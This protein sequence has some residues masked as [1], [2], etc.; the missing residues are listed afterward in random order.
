MYDRYSRQLLFSGIGEEGQSKI[1]SSRAV[2]VGCGALGSVQADLLARAGVG[3]LNIIDRDFLELSNL[4]RQTLFDEQDL[5]AGLPK[6]VA[7]ERRLKRI[8]SQIEIEGLVEDLNYSNGEELLQGADVI[9]DGTDN[10]ET[11]FLINDISVK[12]NIP[13]IYGACVGS[14]GLTMAVLPGEGPCLRCLLEQPPAGGETCDTAGV[15]APVVYAVA[16]LQAAEALKILAGRRA[17][18]NRKLVSIDVWEGRFVSIETAKARNENC[19]TCGKRQFEYLAGKAGSH[20]IRLCGRNAVQINSRSDKRL[21]FADLAERLR[22]HGEVAYNEYLLKFK[23]NGYE[24][25]LF[26]DGRGIVKGTE[27]VWLARS[28]YARYI[29]S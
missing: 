29:G 15:V 10:F 14:H 28:L 23:I 8:N 19:P 20:A 13:W 3:R 21:S 2:I 11:R 25:A 5:A 1:L 17:A 7:A 16:A 9:L 22:P 12:L 6:A 27:D 18:V 4:Q 24:I 26:P